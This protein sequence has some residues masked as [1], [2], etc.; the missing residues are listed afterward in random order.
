VRDLVR[1]RAAVAAL[2]A[3]AA[4]AALAACTRGDTTARGVTCA[5]AVHTAAAATD[6]DDQI[7]LLD[8]AF[9]RCPTYESYLVE[10]AE[11]PGAIGYSPERYIDLRCRAVTEP[12]LRNSPTCRTAS[13]PT[14]LSAAVADEAVYAAATLDGRVV[15]LRE[16]DGVQ[17]SGDVP[18]VVQQ[19]VDIANQSG[20]DGVLAQ[21]DEWLQRATGDGSDA[22]DIASVYAQHAIN[23]AL[24]IGCEGAQPGTSAPASTPG[25][26]PTS[27]PATSTG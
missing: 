18:T 10:L 3:V 4:P 16:S 12:R 21:R 7:R 6:V 24:W 13:P 22:A 19:T 2:V 14:T 8:A 15:E 25:S 9:L 17:F 11:Y 5:Q 1:F 27:A 20:C 26:A 23:V